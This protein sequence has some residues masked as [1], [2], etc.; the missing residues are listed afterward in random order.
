MTKIGFVHV[1]SAELC[2]DAVGMTTPLLFSRLGTIERTSFSELLIGCGGSLEA[3]LALA[4]KVLRRTESLRVVVSLPLFQTSPLEA[5][6]RIAAL[7]EESLG[8]ISVVV[9]LSDAPAGLDHA[10]MLRRADEFVVLMKRFWAN[11]QPITFEGSFY[12]CDNAV[13]ARKGP[14]RAGIPL[15]TSGLS[16]SAVQ[17]AGRHADVFLLRPGTPQEV[18][19][20]IRRTAAARRQFGRPE[21]RFVLPV[22]AG[23]KPSDTLLGLPADPA[24]AVTSLL[25]YVRV[26]V[27]DFAVS[28]LDD[29]SAIA[30]FSLR[31]AAPAADRARAGDDASPHAFRPSGIDLTTLFEAPRGDRPV[32]RTAP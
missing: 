5:A 32:P 15:W 29:R 17:F 28:G 13:L 14:Q 20:Q 23:A 30:D 6:E 18:A 22:G 11:D 4:T 19:A 1:P 24:R 31:V 27:S 8:R 2:E 10:E 12:R 9:D 3:N 26:G 21:P 7:D 16:G 25:D